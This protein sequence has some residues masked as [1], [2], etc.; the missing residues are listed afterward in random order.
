MTTLAE[1]NPALMFAFGRLRE[2][3]YGC[4][5]NV[6]YLLAEYPDEVV[7]SLARNEIPRLIGAVRSVVA[8]HRPDDDGRCSG[9]GFRRTETGY[10]LPAWPCSAINAM[11]VYLRD[12]ARVFDDLGEP[13][14]LHH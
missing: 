12:P 7:I 9:C 14:P 8:E 2:S 13:D 3:M 11:H 4:I 5:D 1:T 10:E 6:E